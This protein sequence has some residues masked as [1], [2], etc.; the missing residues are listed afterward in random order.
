[1]F[2]LPPNVQLKALESEEWMSQWCFPSGLHSGLFLQ[3]NFWQL[4]P[5]WK[6]VALLCSVS[7]HHGNV[8]EAFLRAVTAGESLPYW[9]LPCIPPEMINTICEGKKKKKKSSASNANTLQICGKWRVICRKYCFESATQ[10]G[11]VI[12]LTL[13]YDSRT[14][15]CPTRRAESK[16]SCFCAL[17]SICVCLCVWNVYKK[18]EN[19]PDF[20]HPA[21]RYLPLTTPIPIYPVGAEWGE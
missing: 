12:R 3:V 17:F 10:E 4:Q 21:P 2:S 15:W 11:P 19:P 16:H 5:L 6:T 7:A 20:K 1:M 8:A 13:G 18:D 9:L 14:G